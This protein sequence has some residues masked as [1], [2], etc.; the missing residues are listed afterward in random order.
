MPWLRHESDIN[1]YNHLLFSATGREA[2]LQ[3]EACGAEQNATKKARLLR[4]FEKIQ[5]ASAVS[6]NNDIVP[7]VYPGLRRK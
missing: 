6:P 2:F 4:A 3:A 5:T 1:F 7:N